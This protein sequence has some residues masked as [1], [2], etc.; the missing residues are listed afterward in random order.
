MARRYK[1]FGVALAAFASAMVPAARAQW[2]QQ[3]NKLVGSGASGSVAARQGFASAVSWD[4]N[5]LAVGGFNN[6]GFV[7]SVWIFTRANGLWTQQ[8]RLSPTSGLGSPEMG[9]SVALSADGNTGIFGAILDNGVGAAFIFTRTGTLWTQ[10]AK[11]AG[12]SAIGA[13]NQGASVGISAD[14][15]TAVVGAPKDNSNAGAAWVFTQTNGVWSQQTKLT[16]TGNVGTANFGTSVSVSGDGNT[17]VAGGPGDNTSAGAA[18]VFTRANGVWTQQTK[19]TGSGANGAASQ[20][21]AVAISGQGDTVMVGGAADN[22]NAGAAWVFTRVNGVWTQQGSKLIGSNATG[23]Q[24]AQQGTAVALSWDGNTAASGGI[25][26]ANKVGAT[27]VFTRSNGV[28]TQQAKVTGSGSVSTAFQGES[29]GL[30]ADATTLVVGG[31]GDNVNVGAEWVFVNPPVTSVSMPT[32]AIPQWGGGAATPMLFT[33]SDPRGYQDLDV[34]NILINNF[35]D[36]RQACYLAYSQPSGVLY[37][38]NDPG[39]ALLPGMVLGP[40]GGVGVVSNSQ[41][42]VTGAGSSAI[43]NGNALAL[44]LNVSFGAGFRGNKVTYTAARD[45]LGGNSDWQPLGTWQVPGATPFPAPAGIFPGHGTGLQQTFTVDI[46][47]TKGF[48]DLGVVNVLINRFIDGRQACYLAYS[49]PAGVLYLV[50]DA[51]GGLSAPL[52]LGASGTVSNSQCTVNSA[53]SSAVGS[54]NTLTLTLNMTFTAG[55]AGNRA[56]YLAARDTGEVNN[57]DWQAMGSW[58]FQ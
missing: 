48:Q 55:F 23:P 29:V 14:G 10:Q 32:A 45:L 37:L 43:G 31:D 57:S 18:W 28:W 50:G 51:G 3:G 53:G 47:D 27:W 33:F 34:V 12:T 25:G 44:T 20:G 21:H 35:L 42:T 30:S 22:T 8:A 58:T 39:T 56:I 6:A 13:S 1:R 7:G 38:V 54:G 26:D 5:T 4:G 49:R 36:G 19:L 2:V 17:L 46:T 52:T 41:C 11:L 16:E 24:P 9:Y 40:G 15:S